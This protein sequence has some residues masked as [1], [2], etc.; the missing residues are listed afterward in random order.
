MSFTGSDGSAGAAFGWTD[1]ESSV[2]QVRDQMAQTLAPQYYFPDGK[3][4]LINDG[5]LRVV[6]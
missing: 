6:P 2:A 3:E 4:S 1:A 5:Y